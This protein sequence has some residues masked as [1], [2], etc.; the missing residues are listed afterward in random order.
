MVKVVAALISNGDKYLIARRNHGDPEANG[1][2]EFPGGK[3]ESNET[4]E[5]AI[6]R[7]MREEFDVVVKSVRFIGNN[8]S[9]YEAR[10]IDI[11]LYL[12][13]YICGVFKLHDH[14]EIKWVNK[15]ELMLYDFAPADVG[16][17][18]YILKDEQL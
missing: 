3:L 5:E 9:N 12:C 6:E 15:N 11:N 16:L 10:T 1:K 2:W 7:E 13:N 8:V 14:H 4:E 18:D 17:I